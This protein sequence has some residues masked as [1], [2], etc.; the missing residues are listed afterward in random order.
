[1]IERRTLRFG[2]CVGK[3]AKLETEALEDFFANGQKLLRDWREIHEQM[4]PGETHAIP[5]ADDFDLHRVNK[6]I[7]DTCNQAKAMQALVSDKIKEK[8]EAKLKE[9]GDWDEMSESEK[10]KATAVAKSG[11]LHHL[12]I[13]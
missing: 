9:S 2:Y 7:S 8:I 5:S 1:M 6:T 12:R 11:C 13:I 3:S 10:E 4:Y